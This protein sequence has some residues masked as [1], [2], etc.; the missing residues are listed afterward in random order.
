MSGTSPVPGGTEGASY[1]DLGDRWHTITQTERLATNQH[2]LDVIIGLRE[3]VRIRVP[4]WQ[5]RPDSWTAAEIRY[6][7]SRGYRWLDEST[8]IPPESA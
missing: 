8:M 3:T 6:L 2:F 7:E 5:C 4:R 1:F